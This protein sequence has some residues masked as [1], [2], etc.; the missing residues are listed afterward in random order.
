MKRR[1]DRPNSHV[2][3]RQEQQ[4]DQLPTVSLAA[5][6]PGLQPAQLINWAGGHEHRARGGPSQL[7]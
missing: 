2:H 5:V 6:Q 1:A 3:T 7:R 4:Q